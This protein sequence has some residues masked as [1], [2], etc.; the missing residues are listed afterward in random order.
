MTDEKRPVDE[1]RAEPAPPPPPGDDP[2]LPDEPSPDFFE[3]DEHDGW[4]PI[5]RRVDE[6]EPLT[7]SE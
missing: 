7:P 4:A 1:V 6:P 5:R 2:R 3:N